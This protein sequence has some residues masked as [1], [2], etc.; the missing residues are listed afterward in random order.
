MDVGESYELTVTFMES[1]SVVWG[2][3]SKFQQYFAAMMSKMTSL[4]KNIS[5]IPG[6]QDSAPGQPCAAQ[7]SADKQWYRGKI[8]AIDDP[9][10]TAKVVFVDFGNPNIFKLSS[11]KQLPPQLLVL[12]MQAVSFSMHDLAP[13]DGGK[14]WPVTS[15]TS[16]L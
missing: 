10:K 4:F 14:V 16:F 11:L 12:P 3:L 2:Q 8:E 15:Q 9:T 5:A 7:F 6:L 13:A 1:P